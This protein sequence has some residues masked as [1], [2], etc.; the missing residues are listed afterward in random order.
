MKQFFLR[1][2]E[3]VQNENPN[4]GPNRLKVDGI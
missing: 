3:F 1:R 4:N 2:G